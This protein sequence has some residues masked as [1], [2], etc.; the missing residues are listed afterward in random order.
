VLLLMVKDKVLLGV[1]TQFPPP[2][3]PLTQAV[4]IYCT[5]RPGHVLGIRGAGRSRRSQCWETKID[6]LFGTVDHHVLYI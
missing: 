2:H 1:D 3:S 5:E 6:W 4:R